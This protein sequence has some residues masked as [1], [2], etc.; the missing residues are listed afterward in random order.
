MV[1]TLLGE[2]ITTRHDQQHSENISD[3]AG[4]STILENL[5]VARRSRS[6]HI[7]SVGV[8]WS[9]DNCGVIRHRLEHKPSGYMFVHFWMKLSAD[10]SVVHTDEFIQKQKSP[11]RVHALFSSLYRQF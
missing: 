2:W 4:R 1:A 8:S 11:V 3:G 7:G 9:S 5:D 6:V 10:Y